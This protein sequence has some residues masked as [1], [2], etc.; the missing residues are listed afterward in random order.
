MYDTLS[1]GKESVII[2]NSDFVTFCTWYLVVL[3][4]CGIIDIDIVLAVTNY[5]GTKYQVDMIY[6]EVCTFCLFSSYFSYFSGLA[7]FVVFSY[8]VRSRVTCL[9]LINCGCLLFL[10][11][12]LISRMNHTDT[13]CT[14]VW[15]R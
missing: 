3:F 1:E 7:C 13:G 12:S 2:N 15:C 8:Q 6:F 5:Q 10:S 11:H 4:F 14:T 9:T